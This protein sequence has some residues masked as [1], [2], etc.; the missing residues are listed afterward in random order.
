MCSTHGCTHPLHNGDRSGG[1]EVN[2]VERL[3]DGRND[4]EWVD[5][6]FG[7]ERISRVLFDFKLSKYKF[8]GE[9]YVESVTPTHFRV[10][11]SSTP[12]RDPTSWL[13]SYR[14]TADAPWIL[15]EKIDSLDSP[16]QRAIR[17]R[18]RK[19]GEVGIRNRS[20]SMVVTV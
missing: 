5:Y 15:G 11:P 14:E 20:S 12:W 1:V 17:Q 10:W 9:E 13:V 16:S 4:T 19:T 6:N 3:I 8:M 2:G 7:E 18:L